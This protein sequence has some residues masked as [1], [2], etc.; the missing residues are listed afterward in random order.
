MDAR[1]K[2]ILKKLL[3]NKKPITSEYLSKLLGVSSRTIR[4]D[5]KELNEEL[6]D[7]S[8]ENNFTPGSR[9]FH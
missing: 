6:K 9:I 5:I 1:K 7:K 4:N 8:I 3:E 2:K